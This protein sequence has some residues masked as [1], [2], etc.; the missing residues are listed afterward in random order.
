MESITA[1]IVNSTAVARISRIVV[2]REPI[3]GALVTSG[4]WRQTRYV[5]RGGLV[6]GPPDR[7]T[8]LGPGHA[9]DLAPDAR[10]LYLPLAA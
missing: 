9:I 2:E 8:V 5:E 6:A 1:Q 4:S 7:L 3:L 10:F